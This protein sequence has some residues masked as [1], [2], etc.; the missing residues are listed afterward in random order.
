MASDLNGGL[1]SVWQPGSSYSLLVSS[2]ITKQA[3]FGGTCGICTGPRHGRNYSFHTVI[4]TSLVFGGTCGICMGPCHGRHYNFSLACSNASQLV[5]KA[6]TSE[7]LYVV[8]VLVAWTIWGEGAC[9]GAGCRQVQGA[10]AAHEPTASWAEPCMAKRE[11]VARGMQCCMGFHDASQ[12][13]L[14]G[15]HGDP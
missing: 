14:M 3:V 12:R 1:R 4:H 10:T 2:E 13:G 9:R 7:Q 5:T 11:R 15:L 8:R 6:V